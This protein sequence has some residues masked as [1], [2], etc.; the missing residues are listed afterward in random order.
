MRVLTRNTASARSKLQYPGL[1]FFAPAQWAEAVKG[2][3]AVV[4]L[5]GTPIGTRCA[6]FKG[7]VAA[8]EAVMMMTAVVVAVC[9]CACVVWRATP[10]G[11]LNVTPRATHQR[12]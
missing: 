5:A 10:P 6:V 3:D 9:A 12:Q 4:N 2:C 11:T 7:G 1:E 8:A